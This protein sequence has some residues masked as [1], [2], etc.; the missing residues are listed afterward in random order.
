MIER[1]ASAITTWLVGLL[2]NWSRSRKREADSGKHS[3]E[4]RVNFKRK[5]SRTRTH[6]YT[7]DTP[8]WIA[9]RTAQV[10]EEVLL[11]TGHLQTNNRP[12][13][14]MRLGYVIP[15]AA[16]MLLNEEVIGRK[17]I[18]SLYRRVLR[19]RR[20]FHGLQQLGPQV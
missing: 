15:R 5:P 18:K 7:R 9:G 20:G 11:A 16:V 17:E 10:S 4:S 1:R 6:G 12:K 2:G 3:R 14:L 13:T 8:Q 19:I